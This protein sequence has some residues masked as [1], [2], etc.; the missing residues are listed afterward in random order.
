MG[1]ECQWRW[2]DSTRERAP[3]YPEAWATRRQVRPGCLHFGDSPARP[4]RSGVQH[5]SAA[6]WGYGLSQL[7]RAAT[8]KTKQGLWR[9]PRCPPRPKALLP[10]GGAP[11]RVLGSSYCLGFQILASRGEALCDT[12]A[13]A[14]TSREGI[15]R[16]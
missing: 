6:L 3:I 9:L 5:Y 7:L 1:L 2:A 13:G 10:I 12:P 16:T 14:H 8:T 15:C 11:P 4:A